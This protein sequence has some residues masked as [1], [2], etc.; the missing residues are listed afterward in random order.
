MLHIADMAETRIPQIVEQQIQGQNQM[1]IAENL[2]VS[3]M[4]I[5]RDKQTPL[6]RILINEFLQLY[7]DAVQEHLDSEDK[8][9][10]SEGMKELGRMYRAGMT[11][12][13]TITED[14]KLTA[15]LNITEDRKDKD[16]LVK[17]LELTPD[18]YRVLEDSVTDESE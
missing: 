7:M 11:K 5:Y 8:Y 17:S 9:Q 4:T 1:Q 6:Y 14:I 2:G 3:R 16:S 10:K 13:T 12:H 15:T 18:Q